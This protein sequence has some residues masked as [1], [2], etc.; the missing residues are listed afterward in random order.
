MES[1]KWVAHGRVNPQATVTLLCFAYPGGSA[2]NFATWKKQIAPQINLQPIL[3]PER[4]IRKN[5]R[6]QASVEQFI[7][8]FV[9]ENAS[10]F[11]KPYAF[12]GYCGGAVLAYEAAVLAKKIYGTSPHWGFIASSE[13]PEHLKE[14][15]VPFPEQTAKEDM[16]AYLSGLGILDES[17]LHNELFLN[18]YIPLLQ[19]DCKLLDTYIYR[20]HAKLSCNL[21]VLY[22]ED[23]STVAYEKTQ[24]WATVT[25]GKTELHK[26]AGGHFFV[27]QQKE[28][29]CSLINKRLRGGGAP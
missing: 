17:V 5:D 12:F 18:Y 20:P 2:G 19:A 6:M 15:L 28:S 16:I 22:G 13:A 21:D 8:E 9:E 23:D 24:K 3:Y 27:E 11:E 7:T 14:S 25:T 1:S 29:V 26:Y 4:E 10:L